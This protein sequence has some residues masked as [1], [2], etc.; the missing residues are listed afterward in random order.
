MFVVAGLGVAATY[1]L[2]PLNPNL[3][4]EAGVKD[5]TGSA[6]GTFSHRPLAYRLLMNV[7]FRVADVGSADVVSFELAVRVLLLLLVLGATVLLWKGLDRRG[8]PYAR[9]YAV[10]CAGTLVLFGAVSAGEPEWMAV[11]LTIAGV[12]VALLG[13]RRP[14]LFAG[15]AGTLFVAAS[16]MKIMTL[17]VALLGLLAVF[18]LDRRQTVRTLVASVVIGVIYV[19]ATLLWVPWEVQWL[20]D[21]RS[22]QKSAVESLPDALPYF[23]DITARRPVLTVIPAALI[24]AGARERIMISC[25]I[26]VTVVTIFV[27]GQYFEYH[28]IALVTVAAIAV[29]RVFQGRVNMLVGTIILIITVVASVRTTINFDWIYHHQRLWGGALV[30]AAALG[31]AWAIKV[32]SQHTRP[33]QHTVGGLLAALATLALVYPGSTPWGSHLLR[34]EN[35]DGS[36]PPTVFESRSSGQATAR[37]VHQEI[38]GSGVEVT[39]LTSGGWPYFIGNPTRCRYP[40][41]LFLQRTRKPERLTTDSYAE[42]VACLSAPGSRWLIIES[43]W[44]IV[45]KQTDEVKAI[46]DREW[47]CSKAT[48]IGA[49]RLCPRA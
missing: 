22:V 45:P 18:L 19:G 2:A 17:S 40:S 41:P 9:M 6:A 25:S 31:A 10:V 15:L 46:L 48:K 20:L 29:L 13:A 12:G 14:W 44:F 36:R 33:A 47:D 35:P 3:R 43:A 1:L 7:V 42:N 49:L 30:V 16:G 27:Q 28:A 37:R 8:V 4:Y 34:P 24:L 5:V 23:A 11:L 21:I 32:R 26:A 38:G 39:Y